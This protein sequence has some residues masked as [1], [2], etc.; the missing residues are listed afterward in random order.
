MEFAAGYSDAK[1]AINICGYLVTQ[2]I[3]YALN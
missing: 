2:P 3:P 1:L